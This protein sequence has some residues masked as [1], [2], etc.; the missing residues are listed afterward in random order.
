MTNQVFPVHAQFLYARDVYRTH[1]LLWY[2]K[3]CAVLRVHTREQNLGMWLFGREKVKVKNKSD[4]DND[5][6]QVHHHHT[7]STHWYKGKCVDFYML[8]HIFGWNIGVIRVFS[9]LGELNY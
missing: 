4:D 3:G 6:L 8:V 2:S 5:D 1:D 7:N 9:N